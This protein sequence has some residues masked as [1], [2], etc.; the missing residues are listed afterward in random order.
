MENSVNCVGILGG[1]FDP[2]HFGHLELAQTALA[3]FG[4]SKV[5]MLLTPNPP[6]KTEYSLTKY[7]HRLKM[8]SLLIENSPKL[9]LCS[10]ESERP[11]PHYTLETIRL[12]K[13]RN[14]DVDEYWLISGSDTFK[15]LHTWYKPEILLK[16]AKLCVAARPEFDIDYI[17]AL[18]KIATPEK[19]EEIKQNLI[20]MKPKSIS[21]TDIRNLCAK[22]LRATGLTSE[23]IIYYIFEHN[24][25]K[26]H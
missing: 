9:E 18:K 8:L 2:P 26:N 10:I 16:E 20:P 25:Y 15:N 3:T 22:A 12:L 24:L 13:K 23:S 4:F 14:P 21:S 5:L 17:S 7:E 6:H 11:G 19:I 1:S